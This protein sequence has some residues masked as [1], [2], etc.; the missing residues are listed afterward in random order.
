MHRY[1]DKNCPSICFSNK[2]KSA[3]RK[4]LYVPRRKR[5]VVSEVYSL[6]RT[7]ETPESYKG[8]EAYFRKADGW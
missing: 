7:E 8:D 6:P 5:H 2:R 4:N 1:G 3:I